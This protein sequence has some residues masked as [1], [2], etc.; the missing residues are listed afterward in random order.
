[1]PSA[2]AAS[3]RQIINDYIAPYLAEVPVQAITALGLDDKVMDDVR[4]GHKVGGTAAD[5]AGWLEDRLFVPPAPGEP[6]ELR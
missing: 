2:R 6:A 4:R 5:V 1:M 3:Y